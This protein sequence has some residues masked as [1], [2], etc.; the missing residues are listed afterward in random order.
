M[1]TIDEETMQDVAEVSLVNLY[2][3]PPYSNKQHIPGGGNNHLSKQRRKLNIHYV[4]VMIPVNYNVDLHFERGYL[5][6]VL[7]DCRR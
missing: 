6:I 5:I 1:S 4:S 2:T 7:M 3:P